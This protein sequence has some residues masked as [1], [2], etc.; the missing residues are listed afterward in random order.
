MMKSMKV[1]R[2]INIIYIYLIHWRILEER[3]SLEVGPINCNFNI[4]LQ[5]YKFGWHSMKV[6]LIQRGKGDLLTGTVHLL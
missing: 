3:R 2:K 1:K 6:N 5:F 4:T